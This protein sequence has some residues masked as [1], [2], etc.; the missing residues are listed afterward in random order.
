MSPQLL[1]SSLVSDRLA[2]IFDDRFLDHLFDLVEQTSLLQDESL[3]YSVIKLIVSIFIS[4]QENNNN[5]T[6]LPRLR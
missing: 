2:E 6:S 3:N 5:R 4:L 1:T